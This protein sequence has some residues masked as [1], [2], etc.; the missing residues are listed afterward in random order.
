MLALSLLLAVVLLIG[1]Q[2][3]LDYMMTHLSEFSN[4]DLSNIKLLFLV[5]FVVIFLVFFIGISFIYYFGPAVHY[6]W[7]FFS[8]GSLLA[9]L[10]ILAISYGFF[11]LHHQLWKLQ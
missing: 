9:T 7:R 10:V 3:A 2:F 6:N 11:L 5:R 4:L 1:G 8:V